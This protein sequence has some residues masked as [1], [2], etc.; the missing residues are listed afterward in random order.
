MRGNDE[1]Y[2][3]G[4]WKQRGQDGKDGLRINSNGYIR[5]YFSIHPADPDIFYRKTILPN[6]RMLILRHFFYTQSPAF[7]L[8]IIQR[9]S[10]YCG[11]S[12]KVIHM[13]NAKFG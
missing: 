11:C 10:A 3:V 7:R 5:G 13:L 4:R 8:V 2:I 6:E 12:V 9:Q 1:F